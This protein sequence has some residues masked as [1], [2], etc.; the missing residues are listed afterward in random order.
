MSKLQYVPKW[1]LFGFKFCN[2]K[3]NVLSFSTC[4]FFTAFFPTMKSIPRVMLRA[5]C[6][7]AGSRWL[8]LGNYP[9]SGFLVMS[10]SR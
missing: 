10:L 9:P 7:I 1:C 2:V 8:A 6:I 3:Y 4:P 5:E